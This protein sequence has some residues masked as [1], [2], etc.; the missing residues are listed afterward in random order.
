MLQHVKGHYKEANNSLDEQTVAGL[1]IANANEFNNN[2]VNG[3]VNAAKLLIQQHPQLSQQ[4]DQTIPQIR[5][6]AL[7]QLSGNSSH[8]FLA[9]AKQQPLSIPSITPNTTSSSSTLPSTINQTTATNENG[10]MEEASSGLSTVN[11]GSGS[12]WRGSAPYRCGICFQTSNWK[13]VIQVN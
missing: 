6:Q 9:D 5:I 2:Y 12:A 8:I 11:S 10:E 13:H 3:I 4:T 7:N 1:N